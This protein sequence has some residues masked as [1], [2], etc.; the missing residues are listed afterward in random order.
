VQLAGAAIPVQNRAG[1]YLYIMTRW[2]ARPALKEQASDL[3]LSLRLYDR[4]DNLIAQRDVGGAITAASW[5]PDAFY[6]I[7]LALP[8]PLATPPGEY[9]LGLVVYLQATGQPLPL[10]A[11]QLDSRTAAQWARLTMISLLPPVQRP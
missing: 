2:Q 4:K 11:P 10:T 9:Q 1:A 7:P 3:S 5:Q 6:E 8:V